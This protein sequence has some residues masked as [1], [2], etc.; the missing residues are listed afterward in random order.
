MENVTATIA[1][2]IACIDEV[3]SMPLPPS[4]GRK[5]TALTRH[6][7][8][9]LDALEGEGMY[10]ERLEEIKVCR[11][12][13]KHLSNNDIDWLIETLKGYMDRDDAIIGEDMRKIHEKE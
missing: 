8:D 5:I 12:V 9:C 3:R 11:G 10:E 2:A 6:L 7:Y 13:F 1:R 4:I